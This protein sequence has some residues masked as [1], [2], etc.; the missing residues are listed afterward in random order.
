MLFA[1]LRSW[2]RAS[3][4]RGALEQSM[5][6]EM[7]L[8]MEHMREIGQP[9]E[10]RTYFSGV[11]LVPAARGLNALRDRFSLPLLITMSIVGMV[12]LIGCANVASLLVARANARRAEISVRLAIG[13]S[14][15]RVMRQMLTE[16]L[17]L[18]SLG[19][20]LGLLLARAGLSFL[21]DLLATTGD[22]MI[23]DVVFDLRVFLFTA[24]VA[25]A[26][27]LL[28]S[29]APALRTARVEAARPAGGGASAPPPRGRLGQSL[30]VVQVTLSVTLLCA[31]GL[32]VRTLHNLNSIDAGFQ[33]SGVLTMQVEGTVPGSN[34]RSSNFAQSGAVDHARLGALWEG[35]AARVLALPGVAAAG[36]ATMSP[37]TG[38]DRGVLIGVLGVRVPQE[39]RYIHINQVT[40]GYFDAM[41]IDV[42]AGRS[43]T[44]SDRAASS[45]VA[46][47][48][49]SAARTY[50]GAANPIGRIVRFP[51][52]RVED[53]YEV[54]GL[55]R[56]TRYESLRKPDER[57]AYLP[58]EQSIDPI[59]NAV[60]VVRGLADTTGLV[61]AI[62]RAAG[63]TIPAGFVSR[64]ATLEQRV[65]A[66]LIGERLLSILATLFGGLALVLASIGLYGVMAHVVIGRTREIAVRLAVGAP[67]DSVMWMVVRSTVAL[68]AVGAV[69]GTVLAFLA[70][71]L[72]R[73]LLFGV[74]P[75][76]PLALSS[77][78]L[79]LIVVT[80]AAGYLPARRATRIE[81][82]AALRA[83]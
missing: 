57:M 37:L 40:A 83:D 79:L 63:E 46:I 72:I 12:L 36:M 81:P 28:F 66:S 64:V 69:L 38:R 44:T 65:A 29:L 74:A 32:F 13:A 41:R 35:F 61:P 21:V 16:G 6:D 48:N 20:A 70:G 82:A 49:E 17:V 4:R 56:D 78:V 62:R 27:G 2:L 8:H 18:I 9:P 55:V 71:R 22:R 23:L 33:S 11:A 60:L 68:V 73:G 80:A 34:A 54:V 50:F 39:D 43:F 58:I 5:H 15:G 3:L 53:P 26:T 45:R 52:Q 77:A 14:R 19:A 75:A 25:T 30:V 59:V 1:R 47:L 10:E 24:A 76:D 42:V 51:G 31:A 67:R 7:Q